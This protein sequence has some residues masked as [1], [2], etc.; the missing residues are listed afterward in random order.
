MAE[1]TQKSRL[2]AL[3]RERSVARARELKA[4][5]IEAVTIA[6]AVADGEVLR[7]GRG[8]YRLAGGELD[9]GQP[10]AEAAQRVL[11][12]RICMAS[13]LAFY[14]LIDQTPRKVWIA[15]GA[16]DWPPAEGDPPLRVVR[17]RPPY[18]DL[19]VETHVVGG[20]AVPIYS[21]TKSLADVF[22]N[23]RMVGR[24]VAIEALR[25][26]LKDRKATPAEIAAMAQSAGAWTQMRPYLE[27]MT[28]D[29]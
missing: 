23:S 6:R 18:L 17:F 2:V 22:R 4:A 20:V 7:V 21:V 3:L 8:L 1:P 26:A 11:G 16:K 29:G 25:A 19:G 12:G 24:S 28:S 5:G 13:A 10:L 15:I 14:G 27:A 9:A